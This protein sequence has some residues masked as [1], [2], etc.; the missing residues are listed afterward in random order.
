MAISY[1]TPELHRVYSLSG[2]APHIEHLATTNKAVTPEGWKTSIALARCGKML[3]HFEIA[4]YTSRQ[5]TDG[6]VFLILCSKCYPEGV[7]P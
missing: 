1:Q 2:K 4:D 5:C 7:D 3:R 6:T